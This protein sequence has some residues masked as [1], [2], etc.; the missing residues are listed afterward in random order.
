MFDHPKSSPGPDPA[1]HLVKRMDTR[2]KPAS[3]TL[4]VPIISVGADYLISDNR[5]A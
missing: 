4:L 2:V 1:I 5:A 3:V